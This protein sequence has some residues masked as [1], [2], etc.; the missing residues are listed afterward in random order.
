MLFRNSN[1]ATIDAK[2]R[3]AGSAYSRAL[4]LH[5]A[6]MRVVGLALT[7]WLI[8]SHALCA[9]LS[10]AEAAA[11]DKLVGTA[12]AESGVPSASIAI[13]R[14]GEIAYAKAYGLRRLEPRKAA[15]IDT[16]YR[17]A[18]VSKQFTAA[19]VLILADDGKIS[20][21][22]EVSRYLPELKG[23]D[24]VT[25]RQALSHTAGYRE[26]AT[27]DYL[28]AEEQRPTSAQTIIERWAAAPHDFPPGSRWSYSNTGYVVLARLVERVSGQPLGAFLHDRIFAPLNMTSAE[29]MD[30]KPVR[31]ADAAGYVRVAI[32][33]PREGQLPA[34][35]WT[36][37]CGELALD[38]SDLARW[39]ISVINQSLM[40]RA[41]YA[42]QFSEAR[43]KDG[44]GTGYGL[45]VFLDTVR[46][47]RRIHHNGIL[48]GFWS[49]NRIYPDDQTAV[50]VMVNGSY[51]GSPH[52]V[53]ANGIEKILLPD[54]SR[55]ASA[56][57]PR[58]MIRKLM[59]QIRTGALDRSLLTDDASAYL[60]GQVLSDYQQSFVRLGELLALVP[61]GSEQSGGVTAVTAL[62]IWPKA[63]LVVILH[64][65]RDGKVDEFMAYPVG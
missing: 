16:R 59:D 9:P 4:E 36:L 25:I 55:T 54:P 21:D 10:E 27:V 24:H 46:G 11:V 17:I 37:G 33:P 58:E 3:Q 63:Q 40:S 34:A 23:A 60:S 19:A 6:L 28:P 15:S 30:G 65:R 64:T 2:H 53:I 31:E 51:G 41:A 57:G 12:M 22:D 13:V 56:P 32:G 45:G 14:D 29:D 7:T 50:A 47:H 8:G 49:E 42:A 18:S 1:P 26:F 5:S 44:T 62:A 38:A 52:A 43:L 61:V 20:L 48:P 35:G 39:D